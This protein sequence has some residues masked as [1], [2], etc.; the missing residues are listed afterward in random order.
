MKILITGSA[1]QLGLAFQRQNIGHDLVCYNRSALDIGDKE[2]VQSTVFNE[3]P[4]VIVNCAAFTNVDGCET[5]VEEAMRIN[6]TSVGFLSKAAKESNAKLVQI[7]T[8]YVFDGRKQGPYLESDKPN[9]LSVY[10]KSK[11]LGEELAGEAALIVRTSWVMSSDG[12]NM[13]KTILHLLDGK[14]DLFFVDDQKGCPTFTDDLALTVLSLIE[15]D[16]SGIFHVTNGGAVSW[17]EFAVSIA[18]FLNVDVQRVKAISTSELT[19]QRPAERPANSVL[20]NQALSDSECE[21]LPHHLL[22][23]ERLLEKIDSK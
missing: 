16:L 12:K 8:D 18:Q 11:L 9:P 22:S 21:L 15:K 7:S 20:A 3:R 5:H 2:A 1:G 14:E 4:D 10:G 23:L 6:G 17:Y 13:L 19:P